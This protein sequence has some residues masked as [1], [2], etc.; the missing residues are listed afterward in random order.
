M[1]I[2][3]AQV[4]LPRMVTDW[5]KG[6]PRPGEVGAPALPALS[7]RAFEPADWDTI[8]TATLTAMD[9]AGVDAVVIDEFLG[10]DEKGRIVPGRELPDGGYRFTYDFSAYACERYPERFSFLARVAFDDPEPEAV[11]AELAAT[12]GMRCLRITPMPGQPDLDAWREGRLGYLVE[13]AGKHDLPIFVWSNGPDLSYLD[14]Y[15]RRYPDVQLIVDHLG[16]GMGS[17]RPEERVAVRD[18]EL[19]AV[20]ELGRR[21]DNLAVKWSMV[22]T[23][24]V[25]PYPYRDM[26]PHLL[27]ALDVFG[28]E[29]ILWASDWSQHKVQQSWAQ[30]YWWILESDELSNEDK[31]WMLGRSART[32]LRWPALGDAVGNGLYFDCSHGHPSIRISGRDDDEFVEKMRE[33]VERLHPP[34]SLLGTREQVLARARR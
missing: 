22:E 6:H 7:S 5:R 13:A 24:S 29:R 30:S 10:H 11:L 8:L 4:H 1:E 18:A 16:L 34:P 17:A 32:I 9:A 31:Q 15:L 14:Q 26:F 3:D 25:E 21:Y 12:G 2:V 23:H 27:R 28:R 33:H 20:L 19:D